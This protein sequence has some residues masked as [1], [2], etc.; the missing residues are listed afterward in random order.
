MTT[1]QKGV[2]VVARDCKEQLVREYKRKAF[3][4]FPIQYTEI[5]RERS[6]GNDLHI[7]TDRPIDNVYLNDQLIFGKKDI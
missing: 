1:I 3:G 6:I 5:V 2:Q 4:L 7:V